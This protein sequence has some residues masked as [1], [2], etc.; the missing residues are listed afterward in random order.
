M[1]Q[2]Q[3]NLLIKKN[4]AMNTKFYVLLVFLL[5]VLTKSYSQQLIDAEITYI[6]CEGFMISNNDTKVII[7]GLFFYGNES[8]AMDS[9]ESTRNRII[10]NTEPFL[11][12]QL[13]FITHNHGDHYNQP[14]VVNYLKNNSQSKLIAPSDIVKG[15]SSSALEKQLVPVN[16][17]KYESID[18][19]VNGIQL[20][21]YNFQ[22]D[23]GYRTYNLGYFMNIDGLKVFHG[24]DNSLEDSTEYV[25]FKLNEKNIDVLFLWNYKRTNWETQQQ[26]DFI[27]KYINP[28]YIILMHVQGAQVSTLK[29]QINELNDSTF[30]PMIVFNSS[31]EKVSITD[32]IRIT[33]HMPE[34]TANL[35]DTTFMVNSPVN[36]KIPAIFKDNDVND[37]LT[38]YTSTLPAGLDFDSTTMCIS[39]SVAKAKSYTIK[40]CARDKGL[41]PNSTTFKLVITEPT[42]VISDENPK[43]TFIYPNPATNKLHFKNVSTLKASVQIFNAK[44]ELVVNKHLIDNSLDISNLSAGIYTIRLINQDYVQTNK[45][46][47]K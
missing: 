36:I 1:Y 2:I 9:E 29:D 14:M 15:I 10:N 20:T 45:F 24:G 40:V 4:I 27:K 34:K 38:Y 21:I 43:T 31:M 33:N 37:S 19:T 23:V 8:V 3:N 5:V 16:P 12:S 30:P 44:G 42:S 32:T 35:I 22:H 13:F 46:V 17:A 41:C 18:T 47:K 39:G 6:G 25:K 28:K 11:N 26:R 7:D